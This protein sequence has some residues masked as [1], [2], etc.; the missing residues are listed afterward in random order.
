MLKY[1][2]LWKSV[3]WEPSCPCGLKDG[4]TDIKKIIV[5]AFLRKHLKW[6]FVV[7][8]GKHS[9]K[10]GAEFVAREECS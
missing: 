1:Q 6:S 8:V 3:Q 4:Q 10:V 7:R 2:I 9:Q 5:F